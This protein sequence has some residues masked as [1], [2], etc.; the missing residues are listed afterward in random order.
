[1]LFS[2]FYS[3]F[4]SY[5][6][7][8]CWW[9]SRWLPVKICPPWESLYSDVFVSCLC[10]FIPSKQVSQPP[11]HFP[12]DHERSSRCWGVTEQLIR[13]PDSVNSC[14]LCAVYVT[15][16]GV[17]KSWIY[18]ASLLHYR[19]INQNKIDKVRIKCCDFI[20]V[21]ALEISLKTISLFFF[22]FLSFVVSIKI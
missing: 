3:Y 8:W 21:A 11:W 9:I 20:C 19:V 15:Q 2:S 5:L 7:P 6:N 22:F 17:I 1:M 18:V 12:G 13:A 14:L 4:F 10:C 16:N